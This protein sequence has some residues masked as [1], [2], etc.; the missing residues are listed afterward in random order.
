LRFFGV[1]YAKEFKNATKK[2]AEF[3]PQPPKKAPALTHSRHFFY[4]FQGAPQKKQK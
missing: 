3:F 2:I 4:F 1:S